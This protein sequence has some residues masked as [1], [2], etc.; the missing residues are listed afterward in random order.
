MKK[1]YLHNGTEVTE[2]KAEEIRQKNGKLCEA[3]YR[4]EKDFSELKN[5]VWLFGEEIEEQERKSKNRNI[6][7]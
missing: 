6:K 2:E 7:K 5:I 1:W 3:V 4:G